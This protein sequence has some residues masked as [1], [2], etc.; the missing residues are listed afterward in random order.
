M[1]N[2]FPSQWLTWGQDSGQLNLNLFFFHHRPLHILSNT[3]LVAWASEK[4]RRWAWIKM[5]A[6]YS[7][8]ATY[9]LCDLGHITYLHWV[10]IS[11]SVNRV[12]KSFFK[13]LLCE[14]RQMIHVKAPIIVPDTMATV[15]EHSSPLLFSV[16]IETDQTKA[17]QLKQQKEP[18]GCTK[19]TKAEIG[20]ANI[21][22]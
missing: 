12:N 20:K 17:K 18:K 22:T 7:S 8:S 9:E 11:S 19:T 13:G 2:G 1:S 10:G 14:L 5:Q 3:G 16:P 21:K 15:S 6:S 4:N